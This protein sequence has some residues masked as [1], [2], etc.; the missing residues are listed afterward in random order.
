MF[1]PAPSSSLPERLA[2]Y[3]ARIALFLTPAAVTLLLW[4]TS[5]GAAVCVGM[6]L[7]GIVSFIGTA[8][9]RWNVLE[10]E[11]EPDLARMRVHESAGKQRR[12]ARVTRSRR[13]RMEKAPPPS[14][15]DDACN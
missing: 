11:T 9:Y 15:D 7:I 5:N 3:A 13:A 1:R 4:E 2:K 14:I 12:R 8:W 10:A 6:V